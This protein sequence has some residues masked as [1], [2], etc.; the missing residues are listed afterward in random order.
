M[1][2][3]VFFREWKA[4]VLL[5]FMIG[6]SQPASAADL[7]ATR[8]RSHYR[9]AHEYVLHRTFRRFRDDRYLGAR[10]I[11]TC[12]VQ[13]PAVYH[14]RLVGEPLCQAARPDGLSSHLYYYF[15]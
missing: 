4:C 15:D 9:H 2:M 10:A 7:D 14:P 1:A 6:L 12:P 3:G 5:A 11:E 13:E 8:H